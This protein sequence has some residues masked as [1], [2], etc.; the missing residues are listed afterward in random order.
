VQLSA[1]RYFLKNN[2]AEMDYLEFRVGSLGK[3]NG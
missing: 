1:E 3:N 2:L